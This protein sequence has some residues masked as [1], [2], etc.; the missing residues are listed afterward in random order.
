MEQDNWYHLDNV[1]KVFLADHNKRDTRSMRLS[2]TMKEAVDPELLQQALLK[3]VKGRNHFQVRIRR[4]FFW[5]YA[6]P[7]DVLPQVTEESDRP[8]PVLYGKNYRGV[9]HYQVTYFGNRINLDMFHALADGTGA[10]DFLNHIVYQYLL[11]RYPEDMKGVVPGGGSDRASRSI[12]GFHHFYEDHDSF[13]VTGDSRVKAYHVHGRKLPYEQLQFFEIHMSAGE[14]L[15]SSKEMGVSLTS[16]IGAKLMMALYQDMPAGM[17]KMPITISM[18]VNLRDYFP[19]ETARNFFNSV[20]VSHI[21]A[22]DETLA[23]LALEYDA[24]LKERLKKENIETQ[25]FRYEKIEHILFTRLVPLAI[26]Q[27][28]VKY[29]SRKSAK[30]VT[31]VL[32]NMGRIKLP[33]EMSA[34]VETFS[35]YCAGDNIFMVIS[36]FA[37]DLVFGIS[38]PYQAT[39]VLKTFVRSFRKDGVHVRLSATEVI[40]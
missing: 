34:K 20:T 29:F 21:F 5:H 16:Y 1:A 15:S 6:E 18:P 2:M 37:D 38:Y 28:V 8:C 7:T 3:T 11:L 25:M 32:S 23:S 33:P 14:V 24:K 17:R 13:S 31:A 26:K 27:P 9:L 10:L 40:R 30:T 12:D 22:G 19:S 4:G 36:S 35:G 39:G